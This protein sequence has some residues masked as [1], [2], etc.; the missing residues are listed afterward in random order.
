MASY[1]SP[2]NRSVQPPLVEYDALLIGMAEPIDKDVLSSNPKVKVIGV[3]AVGMDNI[4]VESCDEKGISVVNIP[5]TNSD[6][7]AE[8][9]MASV[10]SMS[11]KLFEA[12]QAVRSGNWRWRFELTSRE[13]RG[14]TLGVIGGGEIGTRV[15]R[16][17][18]AFGLKLLCTTR[19]PRRTK[20]AVGRINVEFVEL[21]ILLREADFVCLLV[22][23]TSE[24]QHLIG[25]REFNMMKETAYLVNVSR[26]AVVD[27][28][29]LINTIKEGRNN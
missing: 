11:K 25:A 26:G 24:T 2:H 20:E 28:K 21:K 22:P 15:I 13:L 1:S 8:Y 9:V 18:D 7:V 23:L 14:K 16:L 27:Q 19:S 12:D 3:L 17:A 4:D 29:A 6:S 5:S 10:L